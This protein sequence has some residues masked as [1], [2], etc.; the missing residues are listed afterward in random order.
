MTYLFRKIILLFTAVF[1]ITACSNLSLLESR[2]KKLQQRKDFNAYLALKYLTYAQHEQENY[3]WERADYFAKKGVLA[4]TNKKVF[5]EVPEKWTMKFAFKNV[6]IDE[7]VTGRKRLSMVLIR[8]ESRNSFPAI[9]ANLQFL[10]DCWLNEESKYA[11]Y[12]Q[13]AKCKDKFYEV[14]DYLEGELL[15]LE[16]YEILANEAEA[17]KKQ[18]TIGVGFIKD[19]FNYNIYFDF[20]S[21]KLNEKAIKSIVSLLNFLE[22][23]DGNYIVYLEGHA[24]RVG[25]KLYNDILARKRMLTIRNKLI[26]NGIPQTNIKIS[27]FGE[28]K[29]KI[30]TK[31]NTKESLNRRVTIKVEKEN[32]DGFSPIP[33]PLPR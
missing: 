1:I 11:I 31:N 15:T 16:E 3:N 21:Y 18:N 27:S 5:P 10:Y 4:A 13:I 33:L 12:N 9:S 24:D 25:K 26:K 17:N 20:N 23:L 19:D 2:Q 6:N 30:I 7:M 22:T 29:P 28:K 14:L 8:E 32:A